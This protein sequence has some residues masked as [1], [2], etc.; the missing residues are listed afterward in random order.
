MEH[1]EHIIFQMNEF[2]YV[3]ATTLERSVKGE[4]LMTYVGYN[5]GDAHQF[6]TIFNQYFE[7]YVKL[8]IF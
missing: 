3:L 4:C 5:V 8:L 6:V 1:V 7:F 2:S